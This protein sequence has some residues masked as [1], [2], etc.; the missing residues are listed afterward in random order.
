MAGKI[1]L[2]QIGHFLKAD[3]AY[4][5]GVARPLGIDVAELEGAVTAA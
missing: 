3:P 5:E 4:E 1:W 2:R